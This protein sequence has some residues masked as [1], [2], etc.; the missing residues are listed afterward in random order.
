MASLFRRLARIAS[1]RF[2]AATS[3]DA[4][5]ERPRPTAAGTGREPAA[6]TVDPE[7]AGYYANLEVPYGADLRVVRR[8]RKRLMRRYHPDLHGSDPERQRVATDLVKGLNRAYEQL[9]R[10]LEQEP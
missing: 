4:G 2:T 6:A 5:R 8:A 10:H 7:L 3:H 9:R 1:A